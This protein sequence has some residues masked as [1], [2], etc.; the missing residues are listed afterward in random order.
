MDTRS[1][2]CSSYR[3]KQGYH[4]IVMENHFEKNIEHE[5]ETGII[6]RLILFPKIYGTYWESP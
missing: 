6:E 3:D 4:S 2:D 1:L 5:M